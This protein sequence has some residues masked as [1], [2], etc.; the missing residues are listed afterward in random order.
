MKDKS[1]SLRKVA[2][3]NFYI[4]FQQLTREGYISGESVQFGYDERGFRFPAEFMCLREFG[5]VCSL[6]A[7][8]FNEFGKWLI[9]AQVS[10]YDFPLCLNSK[11]TQGLLL[12]RLAEIRYIGC[13]FIHLYNV[14][15]DYTNSSSILNVRLISAK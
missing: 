6:A 11:I 2:E 10:L 8:C 14:F 13:V 7:L 4:T 1:V 12:G 5:S 9:P 15:L 3:F